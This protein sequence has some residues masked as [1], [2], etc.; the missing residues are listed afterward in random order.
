MNDDGIKEQAIS[1]ETVAK[2]VIAYITNLL[3]KHNW[4]EEEAGKALIYDLI[5]NARLKTS[6]QGTD[7]W[8]NILKIYST[9]LKNLAN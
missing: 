5:K 2:E 1:P 8:K 6:A 3:Q 4:T 7:K 9:R